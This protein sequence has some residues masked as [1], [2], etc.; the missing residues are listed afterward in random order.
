MKSLKISLSIFSV[1]LMGALTSLSAQAAQLSSAKALAVKGSVTKYAS[2]GSQTK[3]KPGDILVEGDSL[4][5]TALSSAQLVF[6]NGSQITVKENTSIDISKL[7]QQPFS[8]SNTYEQLQADPSV[9]QTLLKIN[10]GEIDFHVKNLRQGSRF[11]IQSPIGTAAVRGT[12]GSVRLFFNAERGEFLFVV[13]NTTGLVDLISRF[14]GDI[15]FRGNVGD[16]GFNSGV[17]D[18]QAVPVPENH[19]IIIR[20]GRGDP[21]F[22]V[23]FN[24]MENFIPTNMN[25]GILEMPEPQITPEDGGVIVVSPE[26]QG[27]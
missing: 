23:L 25:R 6:S 9:S 11:D 22:D 8:G 20:L 10:Y 7:S 5:V 17:A 18:E 12:Q 4:S 19:S 16:A 3:L 26:M 2:D 24:A 15:E 21:L 1:L 14:T 13:R 27:S